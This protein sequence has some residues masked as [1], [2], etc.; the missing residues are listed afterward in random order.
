MPSPPSR[1][2]SV[3]VVDDDAGVCAALQFLLE[4]D[5]QRVRTF[6][7]ADAFLDHGPSLSVGCLVL[8]YRMPGRTGL[9]LMLEAR[10][11][12]LDAPVIMII[13]TP[14]A[15]LRRRAM[16]AGVALV[17]EKPL[18]E[19]TFLAAVRACLASESRRGVP[20][21]PAPLRPEGAAS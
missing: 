6:Q 8:D 1:C 15:A 4:T 19:D 10:L 21:A 14:D 9:E 3:V 17:L 12:G 2:G 13:G 5:G 11:R 18:A 16:A 20:P 7:S